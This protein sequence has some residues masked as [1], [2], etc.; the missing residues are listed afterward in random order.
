[1]R[2]TRLTCLEADESLV[3]LDVEHL[4]SEGSTVLEEDAITGRD[5][6]EFVALAASLDVQFEI[7]DDQS[8]R[9]SPLNDDPPATLRVHVVL[10]RIVGT[11]QVSVVVEARVRALTRSVAR[12]QDAGGC[13]KNNLCSARLKRRHGS[14]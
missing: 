7:V 2:Q 6:E 8:D 4:L 11:G 13:E 5:L 1:M 10:A 9:L 3:C 12:V 14:K